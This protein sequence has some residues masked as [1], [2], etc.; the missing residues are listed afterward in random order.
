[1]TRFP[2]GPLT[3]PSG[4][5]KNLSIL[6]NAG[7]TLSSSEEDLAATTV[8]AVGVLLDQEATMA[9]VTQPTTPTPQGDRPPRRRGLL[10]AGLS[11]LLVAAVIVAAIVVMQGDDAADTVVTDGRTETGAPLTE[12]ERVIAAYRGYWTAVQAVNTPP[13]NPNNPLLAV[14][15]TGPQLQAAVA[16]ANKKV[17][18]GLAGKYPESTVRG[19]RVTSVTISGNT[20]KLESCNVDDSYAISVKTGAPAGPT[21]PETYVATA[22]MVREGVD[23]KVSSLQFGQSWEGVAGCATARP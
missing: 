10:L 15:A 14:Y 4:A 3:A 11:S 2:A 9:I 5:T 23:W 22:T 19:Q 21:G 8:G 20:A 1:M 13:V 18:D 6:E 16:A 12:E 17:A 7:A